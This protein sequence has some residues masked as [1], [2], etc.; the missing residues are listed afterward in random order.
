M[1][2]KLWGA[3]QKLRDGGWPKAKSHR[4]GEEGETDPRVQASRMA[5]FWHNKELEAKPS[6]LFGIL[7]PVF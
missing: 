5:V 3:K 7:L 4:G 6:Q 2:Q 1:G